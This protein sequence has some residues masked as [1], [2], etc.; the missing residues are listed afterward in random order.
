MSASDSFY[1]CKSSVFIYTANGW[2]QFENSAEEDRLI[3]Y[4]YKGEVPLFDELEQY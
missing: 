1:T 4:I 2:V 3:L